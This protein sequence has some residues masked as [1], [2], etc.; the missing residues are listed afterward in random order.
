MR[1]SELIALLER[2]LDP[3]AHLRLGDDRQLRWLLAMAIRAQAAQ[4]DLVIETTP[5]G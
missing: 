3:R 2:L 5:I 1:T 4:R